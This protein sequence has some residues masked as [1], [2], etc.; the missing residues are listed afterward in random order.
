MYSRWKSIALPCFKINTPCRNWY[1]CASTTTYATVKCTVNRNCAF[2][3]KSVVVGFFFPLKAM[4]CT[5]C[6]K[7]PVFGVY[8]LRLTA[9][10]HKYP[11]TLECCFSC[12]SVKITSSALFHWAWFITLVRKMEWQYIT[13]TTWP[14]SPAYLSLSLS[15]T[16]C[17]CVCYIASEREPNTTEWVIAGTSGHSNEVGVQIYD[18]N[19]FTALTWRQRRP[20]PDQRVRGRG[21]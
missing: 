6:H 21:V 20:L 16:A 2:I 17:V 15:W 7:I 19:K 4:F 14:H 13:L 1:C 12:H 9:D 10:N 8:N 3:N 5:W 11:V 18:S